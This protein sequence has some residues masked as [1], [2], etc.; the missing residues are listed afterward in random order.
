MAQNATKKQLLRKYP[1]L[2]KGINPQQIAKDCNM[3]AH[4]RNIKKEIEQENK[5]TLWSIFAIIM[6]VHAVLIYLAVDIENGKVQAPIECSTPKYAK[7]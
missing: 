2:N 5:L 4:K 7:K 6:I 1:F 3:P